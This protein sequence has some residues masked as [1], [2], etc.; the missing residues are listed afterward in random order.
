M[1]EITPERI[2]EWFA[3]AAAASAAFAGVAHGLF[4]RLAEGGPLTAAE[5]AEK[6]AVDPGYC[7]R[8]CEVAF[9]YG[10]LERAGDGWALSDAARSFLVPGSARYA[11]GAFVNLM[12]L[13]SFGVRFAECL[14]TGDVPGEGLFAERPIFAPLFGPML[15]GNFRPVF[16]KG[17]LQATKGKKKKKK[18]KKKKNN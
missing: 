16:E 6:A 1:T 5:L 12:L 14:G 2:Q 10:F 8:W 3:G 4:A 17:V 7:A 9:A 13:G 15:E 18:N 11:G